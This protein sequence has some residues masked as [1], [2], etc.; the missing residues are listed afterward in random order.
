MG[1]VVGPAEFPVGAVLREVQQVKALW[2]HL[3]QGPHGAQGPV[4]LW[5]LHRLPLRKAAVRPGALLL[6]QQRP[7]AGPS[8]QTGQLHHHRRLGPCVRTGRHRRQRQ[9]EQQRGQNG[10]PSLFHS[11]HLAFIFIVSGAEKI[12]KAA[13]DERPLFFYIGDTSTRVG[14]GRPAPEK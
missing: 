1:R 11:A 3:V 10:T 8:L 12:G 2:I 7:P 13:L 9:Q 4:L 5:T 6:G 14:R